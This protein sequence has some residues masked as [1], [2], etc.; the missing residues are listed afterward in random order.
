MYN[1]LKNCNNIYYIIFSA[2]LYCTNSSVLTEWLDDKKSVL[3]RMKVS[4]A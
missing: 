3:L 2:T 4:P 1:L